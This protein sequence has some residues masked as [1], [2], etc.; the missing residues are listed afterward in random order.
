MHG[1]NVQVSFHTKTKCEAL[2]LVPLLQSQLLETEENKL[3]P[4]SPVHAP[5]SLSLRHG[6][7]PAS[8]PSHDPEAAGPQS[9]P[10][11]PLLSY[12]PFQPSLPPPD[13]CSL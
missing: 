13:L 9:V 11:A 7:C 4:F 6:E 1:Q 5:G 2:S 8:L 10:L 12:C 3:A